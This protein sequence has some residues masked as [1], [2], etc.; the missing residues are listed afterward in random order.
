MSCA[1]DGDKHRD[2]GSFFGRRDRDGDSQ[3]GSERGFGDEPSR[4]DAV[5]DWGASRKFVPSSGGSGGGSGG[6]GSGGFGSRREERGEPGEDGPSRADT[7]DDWGASRKFTPTSSGSGGFDDK[8]SSRGFGSSRRGDDDFEGGPSRADAESRWGKKFTPSSGVSSSGGSGGF[9]DR[10]SRDRDGESTWG[11]RRTSDA[12]E[13]PA[14]GGRPRLNL[15]PRTKPLPVLEIPPE[16]KL[17][18]KKEP[19][20]EELPVVT[21]PP[22]P[23]PNPFGAARPREEVLKEQGKDWKEE[24]EKLET[25][26]ATDRCASCGPPSW[27]VLH[28]RSMLST[29]TYK[30]VSYLFNT[31]LCG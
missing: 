3:D 10:P 23:K 27:Q 1:G 28:P 21:G 26:P 12:P 19:E 17:P 31:S 24:E 20:P 30:R 6:F 18:E 8:A 11:S 2:R 29:H 25:K 16:A 14:A 9:E 5:D 22:K 4:A 7:V 13:A 15:A